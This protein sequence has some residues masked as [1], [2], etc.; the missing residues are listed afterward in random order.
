MESLEER[1]YI[2]DIVLAYAGDISATTLYNRLL[3]YSLGISKNIHAIYRIIELDLKPEITIYLEK[4][5]PESKSKAKKHLV[6]ILKYYNTE[7]IT[8]KE[9]I[10]FFE[11]KALEAGVIKE[12]IINT[13][14]ISIK[15]LT[16][17]GMSTKEAIRKILTTNKG[18]LAKYS[19]RC[20]L[21]GFE[22]TVGRHIKTAD[23][24]F[25]VCKFC[26]DNIMNR[27][28]TSKIIYTPMGNKR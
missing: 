6:D 3:K 11:N 15:I 26:Y 17:K 21:C 25:Y 1:K 19:I 18:E 7:K 5:M 20:A 9:V 12:K 10:V 28:K 8:V 24:D 27:K 4:I 14:P 22:R 13:E 2:T 16:E 23:E